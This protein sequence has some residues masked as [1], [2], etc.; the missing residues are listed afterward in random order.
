[1][2]DDGPGIAPDQRELVFARFHR[3]S[4]AQAEGSGLG[5]AIVQ[6]IAELH[7]AQVSAV[8]PETGRGVRFEVRW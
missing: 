8:A 4:T 6:E 5:L 7:G 2:E 3:G 1:V